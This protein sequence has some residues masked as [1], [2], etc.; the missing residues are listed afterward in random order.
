MLHRPTNCALIALGLL[1]FLAGCGGGDDAGRIAATE[2]AVNKTPPEQNVPVGHYCY[3]NDDQTEAPKYKSTNY[4]KVT[5]QSPSPLLFTVMA[6][7]KFTWDPS[8]GIPKNADGTY[9][10]PLGK[11]VVDKVGADAAGGPFGETVAPFKAHFVPS[12]IGNK[13]IGAGLATRPDDIDNGSVALKK[14]A[15]GNWV[16][17]N[18]YKE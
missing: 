6:C 3:T 4:V 7:S 18:F 14:N 10:L 9:Y 11:Y 5:P 1:A 8:V 13:L 2:A 15:D 17:D 12:E 16:A